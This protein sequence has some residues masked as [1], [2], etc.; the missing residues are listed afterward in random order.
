MNSLYSAPPVHYEQLALAKFVYGTTAWKKNLSK[1]LGVVGFRGRNIDQTTNKWDRLMKDYKKVKEYLEGI[2]GGYWWGNEHGGEKTPSNSLKCLWSLV[3]PC[4]SAM[5]E[6]V[7]QQQIFGKRMETI[8]SNRRLDTPPRQFGRGATP[9]W[10]PVPKGVS[11]VQF[12][13]G[14]PPLIPLVASPSDCS[15][16]AHPTLWVAKQ[17]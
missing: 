17:D 1:C 12:D 15:G 10:P 8:D 4:R 14:V 5:G 7:G 13:V 16:D 11:G 6:F 2:G 3:I 9:T